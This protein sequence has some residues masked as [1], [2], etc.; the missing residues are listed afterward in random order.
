MN[1]H[2]PVSVLKG[3]N[4]GKRPLIFSIPA[5]PGS[6][7]NFK[8]KLITTHH[9]GPPTL[10]GG[11]ERSMR[12]FYK[13]EDIA[14]ICKTKP[15]SVFCEIQHLKC[16]GHIARM[17][18]DSPQK[19]WLFSKTGNGRTDQWKLLGRD[20]NMEPGQIRRVVSNKKSLHELLNVATS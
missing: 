10:V 19:Q 13:N 3:K 6:K 9:L 4:A 8:G 18:N 11:E 17:D 14:R 5:S 12:F 20:W 15:A 7:K 16:V 2:G 1:F